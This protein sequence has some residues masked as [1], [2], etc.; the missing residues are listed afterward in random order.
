LKVIFDL[1]ATPS[2]PLAIALAPSLAVGVLFS[3]S[4]CA[5]R[6]SP[7]DE[8]N[9]LINAGLPAAKRELGSREFVPFAFVTE[10]MGEVRRFASTGEPPASASQE[11]VEALVKSL[12]AGAQ[13]GAFKAVA[14]FVEVAI[15]PPGRDTKTQAIEVMLEHRDGYCANAFFPYSRSADG[16]LSFGSFFAAPRPGAVFPRCNE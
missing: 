12:R 9:R 16:S 4:G 11:G 7:K 10:E 6:E 1:R 8:A 5:N 13:A 2:K 15:E 14:V 3:C